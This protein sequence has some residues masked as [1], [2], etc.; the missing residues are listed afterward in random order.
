MQ[1]V[2]AGH[3]PVKEQEQL[4]LRHLLRLQPL[5]FHPLPVVEPPTGDEVFLVVA[6]ILRRLEAQE[7]DAQKRR[8][9][10]EQA[11]A[12]AVAELGAVY[13]QHH[14][15]AADQ[16]HH[17]VDAADEPVQPLA[18]LFERLRVH[19][20]VDGDAQEQHAEEHHLGAQEDPHPQRRD[21]VLVFEALE[22]FRKRFHDH[23]RRVQL[24]A[25][26]GGQDGVV[27]AHFGLSPRGIR[28]ARGRRRG[29]GRSCAPGAATASAIP[30]R[31]RARGWVRPAGRT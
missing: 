8:Q 17:G 15:Q 13:R 22:L 20:P 30:G 28:T 5:L 4:H 6:V 14:E 2:Q 27:K 23:R 10:Q 19:V 31:W 26:L 21:L 24:G 11:Q 18:A 7:G 1:A 16:Q 12:A 9:G 29:S 25:L 3:R